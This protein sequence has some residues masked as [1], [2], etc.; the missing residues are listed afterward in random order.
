M[1]IKGKVYASPYDHR[2]ENMEVGSSGYIHEN[3]LTITKPAIFMDILS[4]IIPCDDT[5]NDEPGFIPIKRIGAG[6][7]ES[8]F[9]LDFESAIDYDLTY[10]PQGV[11]LDF[12]KEKER[13]V[14]FT[15]FEICLQ[16][17]TNKE[18]PEEKLDRLKDELEKANSAE[19]F[20]MSI[21]L[22][23]DIEKLEEEL[24]NKK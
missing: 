23:N 19:D 5:D 2:V 24:K 10:E 16:F 11:Y 12:M 1:P 3:Q 4:S 7:T 9:E 14:I 18:T 21:V 17:N 8:D 20:E 6:L 15:E 22:R 13:Y